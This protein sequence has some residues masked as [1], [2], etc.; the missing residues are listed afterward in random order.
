[1]RDIVAQS[2]VSLDKE[3]EKEKERRIEIVT[4]RERERGLP[5]Q[6]REDRRARHHL[7]FLHD[8]IVFIGNIFRRVQRNG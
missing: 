2:K 7:K 6:Q 1:M 4:E 3:T 5:Q 8:K